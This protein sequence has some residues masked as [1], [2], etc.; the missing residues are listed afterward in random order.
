MK[1]WAALYILIWVVLLEFLLVMIP[2]APAVLDPLHYLL[3]VVIVAFA[4]ANYRALKATRVPGRVKRIAYATF[5]LSVLMLVLGIWLA[6][7]IGS[8]WIIP[9]VGVSV[10]HL[11]LFI[12]IV[13]A[14]AIITQ[15]AAV[16]IAYDMWEEHEFDKET[17]PGDIPPA[18]PAAARP[19]REGSPP[20]S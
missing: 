3:G 1:L 12:H 8:S 10:Y 18:A 14:F 13:N 17:S 2:I 20:G 7:S 5:Y 16:A 9:G 11:V 15:A 6:L 19:A 4:Y